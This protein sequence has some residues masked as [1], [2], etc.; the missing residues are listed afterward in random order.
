ML[1][2]LALVLLFA[3]G[4][5]FAWGNGLLE[6]YGLGPAQQSEPQHLEQQIAPQAIRLL[7][8]EELARIQAQIKAEAEASRTP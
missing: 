4:L 2:T 6:V 8:P 7:K 5:Y 1:R 3:N